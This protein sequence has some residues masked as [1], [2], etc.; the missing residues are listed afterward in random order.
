MR[1]EDEL[2][3]RLRLDD[4]LALQRAARLVEFMRAVFEN[5]AQLLRMSDPEKVIMRG[6]HFRMTTPTLAIEQPDDV[7][8]LQIPVGTSV[9]V[10]GEPVTGSILVDVEWNGRRVMM[11]TRDLLER[12]ERIHERAGAQGN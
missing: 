1:A 5:E 9:T 11:F 8:E 12:A 2:V 7:R 4:E 6:Y 3:Q 10:V